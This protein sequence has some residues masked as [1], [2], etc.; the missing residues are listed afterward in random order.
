MLSVVVD[1]C[2]RVSVCGCVCVCVCVGV[3]F[4]I[5]III[6][7]IYLVLIIIVVI[8]YNELKAIRYSY[9]APPGNR[10]GALLLVQQKTAHARCEYCLLQLQQDVSPT[11]EDDT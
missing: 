1:V 4:I 8:H 11:S 5:I 10:R 6:I 9:T 3:L 2:V 7:L